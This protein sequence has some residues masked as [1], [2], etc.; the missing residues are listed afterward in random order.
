MALRVRDLLLSTQIARRGVDREGVRAAGDQTPVL[1]RACGSALLSRR[2]SAV[3]TTA[4]LTGVEVVRDERVELRERVLDVEHLLVE[5]ERLLL[6]VQRE[7]NL[8]DQVLRR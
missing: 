5:R 8:V 4:L 3:T 2:D 6:H 7:R 1:H